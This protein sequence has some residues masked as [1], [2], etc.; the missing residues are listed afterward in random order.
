ML[1]KHPWRLPAIIGLV[2]RLTQMRARV[3]AAILLRVIWGT[4]VALCLLF[5]ALVVWNLRE[6]TV[7]THEQALTT[8]GVSVAGQTGRYIQVLDLIAADLRTAA[9]AE[10]AGEFRQA[11]GTAAVHDWLSRRLKGIPQ[12]SAIFVVD[13]SG[14]LVNTSRPGPVPELDLSE[15]EY[16]RILRAPDGPASYISGP[17]VSQITR[18]ATVFYAHRLSA[19]DGSFLGAIVVAIDL[20]YLQEFYRSLNLMPGESI[21]LLRQD[22]LVLTR[23][24]ADD[25]STGERVPTG[26]GWYS[27]LTAGGGTYR[28]P[29]YMDPPVP[30]YVS[31]HPVSDYPLVVDA[32]ITV[33]SALADWRRAT[34]V[35]AFGAIVAALAISSL[36]LAIERQF[37][38]QDRQ[39]LRLQQTASALRASERELREKSYMLEATLEHMD[40]GLMM[41]ASD[42]TV[43]ICNRRAVELLEL[44]KE[45]MANRPRFEDILAYQ[46]RQNE[47]ASSDDEFKDFVRR[48]LLL[49]GPRNYVR[50]RP[51]G[52]VLEVRTTPL[53][54]GEAVRTYT[55]VTE[56]HAVAERLAQ[57]KEAAER[58]SAISEQA[59]RSKSEF[60]ATMSHELRTPLNGIIGFS[61]LIRDHPFGD[62]PE[63]YVEYASDIN[64]NGRH[65][66][67]LVND[68]LDMAKIEAGHYTL[69]E[70]EVR[71]ESLVSGCIRT[72]QL[73]ADAAEVDVQKGEGLAHRSLR[74]DPRALRQV[75]TNL[76]SNAVKF[77]PTGGKVVVDAVTTPE[78]G[79]ALRVTDTGVGMDAQVLEAVGQPFYQADSTLE[80]YAGGSGL[81][82]AICIKL[83]KLHGAELK[84]ESTPGSGTVAQAIFGRDR[85][86]S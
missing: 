53:P 20:G 80:R 1:L 3:V 52:Q 47:F 74:A 31:V 21:T 34:F 63:C 32:N 70:Q 30:V 5:A 8:I 9:L 66:L 56:R 67:S 46:W 44:P 84:L 35:I 71:L 33:A 19:G 79:L 55:D 24:P 72:V 2:V 7:R 60:L 41:I 29:G 38:W 28:S 73:Q 75:V 65:L 57:A 69:A 43:P 37:R 81:G 50:K 22:G 64:T 86:A 48:S 6:S 25:P 42:R 15:R 27:T 40:Q 26:A 77:T 11:L 10:P 16:F 62:L 12:A 36:F 39:A 82:L 18:T 45:L 61:E 23:Y 58:A 14:R 68:L 54:G 13:Q 78:G 17:M 4:A 83:L 76:I 49:G 51:N 85:L 59:S